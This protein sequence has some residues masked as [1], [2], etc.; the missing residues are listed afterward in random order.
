[1]RRRKQRDRRGR[2][3]R[4][5]I[6]AGAASSTDEERLETAGIAIAAVTVKSLLL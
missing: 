3:D 1:M 4:K 6:W 5:V 2:K